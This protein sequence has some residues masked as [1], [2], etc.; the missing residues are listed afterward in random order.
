[1]VLI[2]TFKEN[3]PGLEENDLFSNELLR[4]LATVGQ[5]INN[6]T[7]CFTKNYPGNQ[8]NNQEDLRNCAL[9]FEN[10]ILIY[11]KMNKT[12]RAK[13]MSL[14]ITISVGDKI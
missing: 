1:M 5:D 3:I 4:E 7:Q 14:E 11:Q 10:S 13:L 9:L 6:S 12:G 8:R 2:D